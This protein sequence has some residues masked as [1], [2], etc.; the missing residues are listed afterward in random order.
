MK[1]SRRKF[2]AALGALT[3]GWF[4]KGLPALNPPPGAAK[5]KTKEWLES[6]GELVMYDDAFRYSIG[7]IYGNGRVKFDAINH[8]WY[9]GKQ[10][11]KRQRAQMELNKHRSLMLNRTKTNDRL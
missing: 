11:T 1:L 10:W 8:G 2:L 4:T 6:K 3:A 5:L 7:P 9:A